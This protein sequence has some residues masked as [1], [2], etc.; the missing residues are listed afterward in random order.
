MFI[1]IKLYQQRGSLTF[2]AQKTSEWTRMLCVCVCVCVCCVI[3]F[4]SLSL[5]LSPYAEPVTDTET[6]RHRATNWTPRYVSN[7]PKALSA[8][9]SLARARSLSL[10]LWPSLV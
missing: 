6:D 2:P 3:L 8:F 4:L 7:L 9:L 5:S 10:S 1:Q